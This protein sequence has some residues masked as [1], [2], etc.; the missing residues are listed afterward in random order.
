MDVVACLAKLILIEEER[1]SIEKRRLIDAQG[2]T[3]LASSLKQRIEQ[4]LPGTPEAAPRSGSTYAGGQDSPKAPKAQGRG[5]GKRR[6][7]LRR[8]LGYGELDI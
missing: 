2:L 1:L 8:S 7:A 3:L 4:F 6:G 5:H